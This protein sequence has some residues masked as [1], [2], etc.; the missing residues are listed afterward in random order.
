MTMLKPIADVITDIQTTKDSKRG[1]PYFNHLSTLSE[2]VPAFGW[3]SV[4]SSINTFLRELLIL[5]NTGKMKAL[6]LKSA[7]HDN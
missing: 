7:S 5:L 3:V 6:T 2:A 4:V 1:S